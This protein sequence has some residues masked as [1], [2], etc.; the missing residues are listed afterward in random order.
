MAVQSA[1]TFDIVFS[2]KVPLAELKKIK[3]A[4]VQDAN[5][6]LVTVHMNGELSSLFAVLAK[7][8]VQ[9]IDT[10]NLDLEETFLGFYEN[11][12]KK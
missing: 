10:R 12:D 8:D 3:D 2:G 6:D 11:G 9:K 1:Q 4:K 5:G 7:H